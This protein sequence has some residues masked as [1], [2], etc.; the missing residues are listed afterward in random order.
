MVNG[1][2]GRRWKWEATA[3]A[4]LN[5]PVACEEHCAMK[6]AGV[7]ASLMVL[8]C[9]SGPSTIHTGVQAMQSGVVTCIGP[10][11]TDAD[12]WKHVGQRAS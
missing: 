6:R 10:T 4:Y 11:Y 1:V 7:S 2:L 8:R 5:L 3:R 12:Q 9:M